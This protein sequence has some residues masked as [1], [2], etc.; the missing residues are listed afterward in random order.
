MNSC[1][2][3]SHSLVL[4]NQEVMNRQLGIGAGGM[5][6][7]NGWQSESM[8]P[9]T[10]GATSRDCARIHRTYPRTYAATLAVWLQNIIGIR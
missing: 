5:F 4:G 3:H 8:T 9:D 6:R 1:Q 7:H 2:E 10:V